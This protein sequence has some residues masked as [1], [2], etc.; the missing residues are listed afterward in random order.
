MCHV[1]FVICCFPDGSLLPIAWKLGLV[2]AHFTLNEEPI[3]MIDVTWVP[4]G[5]T[6][7]YNKN[8][9]KE[10]NRVPG[11]RSC[12]AAA[13]LDHQCIGVLYSAL[14][15]IIMAYNFDKQLQDFVRLDD[16]WYCQDYKTYRGM[17]TPDLHGNYRGPWM[18]TVDLD[19]VD[20]RW[21]PICP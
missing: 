14:E 6:W 3:P 7:Q 1:V 12:M 4:Q 20:V 19:S 16:K 11:L 2:F 15:A 21:D 5:P 8:K 9:N 13:L 10:W 17:K 18:R